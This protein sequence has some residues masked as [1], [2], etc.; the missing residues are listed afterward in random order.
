MSMD[1]RKYAQ[2]NYALS[3]PCL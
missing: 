2:S 1:M 3:V